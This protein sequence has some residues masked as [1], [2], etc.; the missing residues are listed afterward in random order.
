MA[1]QGTPYLVL[2]I[3]TAVISAASALYT[4]L[5]H[6]IS[7]NRT[8]VLIALA[9]AE[10]MVTYALE[11]A[12]VGVPAKIFWNQMQYVGIVIVPAAWLVFTLQ[13]TS[14]E[15]WLTLRT[16]ILLSI[17]PLITL[18]LVLTNEAHGLI[19]GP[20]A[21][22]IDGP[23]SILVRPHGVA[24]WIHVA[25]TYALLLTTVSLL[26][27][28]LIRSHHLYRR[29]ARLLLLVTSLPFLGSALMAFGLNPFP[30]LDLTPL[31]VA[32]S[33]LVLTWSLFHLR[34][35]DTV[36]VVCEIVVESM[37]DGV[38]V[39][40]EQNRIVDLNSVAQHVVGHTAAKAVGQS[41]EQVWADWSGSFERFHGGGAVSEEVVVGKEDARCVY[42]VR[43]SPI[44]DWRGHL[45]SRV[46][47]LRDITERKRVE[48][49]L[50]R[51]ATQ[52]ALLNDIG[53]KIAAVLEL[54]TVLERAVRL[55]QENFG[56]HHV[57][58]F[59]VD[60][61]RGELVMRARA[62]DFAHL[63]PPD[64]RLKL[65]QGM[66]GWVSCHGRVLLANDVDAE[67]RYVNLYP[68]VVPTR[69]ELSVPIR[70]GGEVVGVLDAQSPRL[71]GFGE[72][73]VTVMEIL[74]DQVATAIGNAQMYEQ[75]QREVTERQ[76]V[77]QALALKVKQLTALSWA[78]QAVTTSL[79]PSQVLAEIVSLA[80]QVVDSDHTSVVLVDEAGRMGQSAE[81]LPGVPSIE[82]RIRDEGLTSWIVHSCRPVIIDE[83]GEDGAISP[84]LGEGAVR[85]ANPLVVEA[86]IKS[87]AGLPLMAKGNLL[88]VLYLHSLRSAA[89]HGQLSLLTTFANQVAIAIQNARLYEAAQQELGE[90]KRV[91]QAL[92]A[93]EEMAQ[94]ILNATTESV[95]LIDAQGTIL[96]MN[97]TAAQR[98]GKTVDEL[99]GLQTRDLLSRGILPPGLVKSRL[100]AFDE[101]IRT[102][103]PARI[104]D[105]R[106]GMLFDLSFYPIFD[107]RGK[108]TQVA[109]FGRDITARQRAE[110]QA[111]RAERL[112]AMGH[113][114]AALAHEINNPLQAIRGNLELLLAF[115][116][117][118]DERR[119]RLDIS[120]QQIERLTELARRVL[121]FAR[122]ADDTRYP[123][124]IAHLT[125]E[126]LELVGEQLQLARI[127]ATTDFPADLPP[128]LVAPDQIVQVLLNLA[129]NAI[130][131]MP[132]GGHLHVTAH[133]DGGMVVLA[134]TND[135]PHLT[136]EYLE[137][138]FD[139]FFTTKPNGTGLG[140][141]I[142]HSIVH[143]QGGTIS[144]ENLEGE[145]G[146][147]FA[148]TLPVAR[149]ANEEEAIT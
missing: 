127:Q 27:Q 45:T 51:R 8:V 21:L 84:N 6:P 128:V 134:L 108:V 14:R 129:I 104:A 88:G 107:T 145:R 58:L 146:V 100:V 33:V 125:R 78:S 1:W 29:Q 135:G 23:F 74:A 82:Y 36:P 121:D 109:V 120:C 83:I 66:V 132:G 5:R 143:R 111:T 115:D 12:S 63:F 85:F 60:H 9:G 55:V 30:Y 39:L 32:V 64:H 4:W 24:F 11:L 20:A 92:R 67:P 91:E 50:K 34:L 52:L 86:G 105:E 48:E 90:R 37:S 62:G 18:L 72:S 79:D 139:P 75:A 15:K 81:N 131:A 89:F 124:S 130:E 53:G 114:A 118:L 57:A 73:D 116:L 59:T 65:D 42:D 142:S 126:T 43:L 133:V 93:S 19:W 71:D 112:A 80:S 99:V 141:S 41:V 70:V 26:I 2:L 122:P 28:A 49:A 137:Q 38:I 76:R 44:V 110:Q 113:I 123:V 7:G 22:D 148:I 103:K 147:T 17:E 98:L 96:A 97:R 77:E 47:V 69:S 10:W 95:I 87:V 68:D 54:D 140:L 149:L 117:E 31:S 119:K 13:Y 56:Y 94:A 40:D 144:V 16:L 61:E 106:E 102:G 3:V 25:Y 138:I 35:R 101:V 46:A 136:P